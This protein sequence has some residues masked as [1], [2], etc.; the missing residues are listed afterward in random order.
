[1]RKLLYSL[2]LVVC[3]KSVFAQDTEPDKQINKVT[4]PDSTVELKQPVIL[5][6]IGVADPYYLG[7]FNIQVK[8]Y[9]TGSLTARLRLNS[10]MYPNYIPKYQIVATDATGIAI[11]MAV[12]SLR[13]WGEYKAN[14]KTRRVVGFLNQK[15]WTIH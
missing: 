6:T 15:V 13:Y 10:L 8:P 2:C 5:K 7:N 3:F 9:Y 1:M 12:N 4:E 14:Q 11:E